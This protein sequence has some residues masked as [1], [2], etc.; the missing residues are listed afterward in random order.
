MNLTITSSLLA[1]LARRTEADAPD[2]PGGQERGSWSLH[3]RHDHGPPGGRGRWELVLPDGRTLIVDL[4]PVPTFECDHRRESHGYQP[5]DSLR[6]LVQ[7]RD[8]ECTF[9]FC[10]RHARESDFEHA[11]PYHRGGRTC[12][13]NAGARSRRCHQVKQS[14]GWKVTQPR[15]GWHRWETPSGRVYEQEPKRY[16]F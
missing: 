11:V 5:S 2:P 14:P 1:A 6:H 16:P 9:P 10:S 7:I 8:Y 13:C 3:R 15:P 4:E 12:G